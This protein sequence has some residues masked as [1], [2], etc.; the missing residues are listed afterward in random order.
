[1]GG[2]QK[3]RDSDADDGLECTTLAKNTIEINLKQQKGQTNEEV[4]SE[5]RKNSLNAEPFI[6]ICS[7]VLPKIEPLPWATF[8]CLS[9]WCTAP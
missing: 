7:T 5:N 6:R 2:N 4:S 1:M 8:F 9:I 3:Q